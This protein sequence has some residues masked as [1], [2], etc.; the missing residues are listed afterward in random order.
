[1]CIK[2]TK[3][4]FC[5]CTT[6]DNNIIPNDKNEIY[7]TWILTS[8]LGSKQTSLRGKI[9]MP[10]NDLGNGLDLNNTIE[11]LNSGLNY[12]DFN[13]HPKENDCLH[14]NNGCDYPEYQ[15][16]SVIF[17]NNTWQKG[18]NPVFTSITKTIAKGKISKETS[19][20]TKG[21]KWLISKKQLSLSELLDKI[22][23][24]DHFNQ[25]HT[26]ISELVKRFPKDSFNKAEDLCKSNSK[27]NK[28]LGFRLLMQLYRSKYNT[29]ALQPIL[30]DKLRTEDD[31]EILKILIATLSINITS[32]S[33]EDIECLIALKAKDES[34]KP[35]LMDVFIN[36]NHP[37]VIDFFIESCRDPNWKVK[38]YALI[39]LSHT[40][41]W[42]STEIRQVLWENV[43]NQHIKLKH[44]SIYGL[45]CRKDSNIKLLLEKEL[46]NIDKNGTLILEAIEE[47]E[48]FTMVPLLESKLEQIQNTNKYV[49]KLLLQTIQKIKLNQ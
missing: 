6:E 11:M 28:I 16:F 14:I 38:E 24:K 4:T 25:Q 30:F 15:Y 37:S 13:Y 22:S 9:L 8:Y 47:F 48:D 26:I 7:Y 18:R 10:T 40:K 34:I 35:I 23:S 45:A 5:S 46:H 44:H 29:K 39:K 32:F 36:A 21:Y 17:K 2:N 3:L 33:N 12:F 27:T 43:E 41:K 49:A 20:P 31:T 1:M 42:D 19:Q